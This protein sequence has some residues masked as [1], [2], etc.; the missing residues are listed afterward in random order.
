MMNRSMQLPC[1][2]RLSTWAVNCASKI[3]T[4]GV[5]SSRIWPSS[6]G[7]SRQFNV[8]AMNPA[9]SAAPTASKYSRQ[10]CA[11]TAN[12]A[13]RCRPHAASALANRRTRVANSEKVTRRS[14]KMTAVF[15][16][17]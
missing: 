9:R 12:R 14:S 5:Q 17:K 7:D 15:P 16:G 1:R 6:C 8:T 4:V 10:F 2:R 3:N 11:S 13:W